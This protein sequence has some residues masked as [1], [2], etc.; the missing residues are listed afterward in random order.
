MSLVAQL[1]GWKLPDSCKFGIKLDCQTRNPVKFLSF[2]AYQYCLSER[3]GPLVA[4]QETHSLMFVDVLAVPSQSCG[5]AH[6]SV[7]LHLN[8]TM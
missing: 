3:S 6:V 5:I 2:D 1:L 8:P 7:Q 4:D